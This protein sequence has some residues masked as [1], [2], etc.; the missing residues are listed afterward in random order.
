LRQLVSW[1]IFP[2]KLTPIALLALLL[3]IPAAYSIGNLSVTAATN[4]Q[5]YSPG[6][7]V[8]VSGKVQDDQS[9]PVSG[10]TVSIEVDDPKGPIYAQSVS[11]DP[12]G[13]YSLSFTL[14]PSSASGQY[15]IYVT[16][17]KAGYN[18]GPGAQA[19][20]TV[21]GQPAS[22]TTSSSS[23]SSQTSSSS[24]QQQ[25]SKCFIATAT[26]GSE[27]SPEVALLRNFRDSEVLKTY[28]GS[29]FMTAFN[30][31]YYSFSPQ[32]ASYI[33]FYA[34]LRTLMKA[35]LYPLIGIMYV[36][37]RL[38]AALSF[39]TELAVAITGI[40]AGIAIGFVY[41]G[42]L[43]ILF[44]RLTASKKR[45]T[46]LR[47]RHVILGTALPIA[48]LVAAEVLQIGLLMIVSSAAVVLSSLALGALIMLRLSGTVTARPSQ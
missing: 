45:T 36:A 9:N 12:S 15:T 39:N 27:L 28:A 20:F 16:A 42:P 7:G 26:Y 32:V 19:K 18:N 47:R 23:A 48:G 22:T 41:A 35:V 29:N 46:R 34:P 44:S 2:Q 13:A 8:S 17:S 10:A 37:D 31:F 33:T 3:F 21:A 40:F 38:F 4:K 1:L 14:A 43:A 6:D 30:A 11:S 5:Q 24:T 25:S